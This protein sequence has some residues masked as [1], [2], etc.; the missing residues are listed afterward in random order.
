M[1]ILNHSFTKL[2]VSVVVL[3]FVY[4]AVYAQWSTDPLVNNPVCSAELDQLYPKIVSDGSGGAI[5]TWDDIRNTNTDANIYAQRI[6][7]S[8]FIQWTIDGVAICDTIRN[9]SAPAIAV[10]GAGGAIIA[11]DDKREVDFPSDIFAQRINTSGEVQWTA[12]G[13]PVCNTPEYQYRPIIVSDSSGGVII[14]WN[15]F[16]GGGANSNVYAQKINSSGVAQWANNGVLVCNPT[17]EEQFLTLVSDGDGGAIITW[18]DFREGPS[19]T[20]IY[21]QRIGS[22]GEM[23]W[24]DNGVI[25]C[26]EPSVIP[27]ST[28]DGDGGAI[29]TWM[30]YRDGSAYYIYTQ[31][32]DANGDIVWAENG[33]AINTLQ[34]GGNHPTITSD[35]ANGAIITWEDLREGGLNF[36]IYAQKIN[37]AGVVQWTENG[38]AICQATGNQVVPTIVSDDSGGA[39]ITWGD[40]RGGGA[41]GD[42]Y[43]QKINSVGDVQWQTDGVAICTAVKDQNTPTLV[44]DG[45]AG[46]II[47][48]GDK[49]NDFVSAFDIY[50]QQVSLNG[51]LGIVTG[52]A[53]EPKSVKDIGL[54]QN[55][56]NPAHGKTTIIFELEN[57]QMV[58]LKVYNL[59]GKKVST[60]VYENKPAGK[61]EVY[62]DASK[63]SPGIYFYKLQAGSCELIRKMI[64]VQ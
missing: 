37:A 29:I 9:Q 48:W 17:G 41:Y 60:L 15:D 32:I 59:Y 20:H 53:E 18:E 52:I 43:A 28:S 7:S 25:I 46:A 57:N 47:T 5:I 3:I 11:W 54:L 23:L 26:D 45:S 40:K 38:V 39:V 42:I 56:P 22:S 19:N 34:Y 2:I 49:R 4:N 1:K 8:G 51:D 64:V 36:D 44:G 21:A 14:A 16:Q 24:T 62:F 58:S 35:D 31:R 50:T 13:I 30:D 55:Y 6:N 10:D 63:I 27:T 61:Y 12:N 33:V